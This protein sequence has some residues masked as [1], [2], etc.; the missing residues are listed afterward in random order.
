VKT[1]ASAVVYFPPHPITTMSEEMATLVGNSLQE[2]TPM[3]MMSHSHHHP[4]LKLPQNYRSN[5]GAAGGGAIATSSRPP[6]YSRHPASPTKAS[7]TALTKSTTSTAT[8]TIIPTALEKKCDEYSDDDDDDDVDDLASPQSS[9]SSSLCWRMDPVESLSDWT[10]S[11]VHSPTGITRDYHV[12]RVVL[13]VGQRTCGYFQNLFFRTPTHNMHHHQPNNNNNNNVVQDDDDNLNDQEKHAVND[14][15]SD[16]VEPGAITSKAKVSS[17][18]SPSPAANQSSSWTGSSVRIEFAR[19]EVCDLFPLFLDFLYGKDIMNNNNNMN[20]NDNHHNNLDKND[21]DSVERSSQ[22]STTSNASVL[23]THTAVGLYYLA[24]FFRQPQLQI[25]VRMF[26]RQDLRFETLA[27]YYCDVNY[28]SD[29]YSEGSSIEPSITTGGGDDGNDVEEEE[30]EFLEQLLTLVAQTCAQEIRNVEPT[31][32]LLLEMSPD[33]LETVLLL[34]TTTMTNE[35]P[36]RLVPLPMS[37]QFYHHLSILVAEYCILHPLQVTPDDFQQLTMPERL[38]VLHVSAALKLLRLEQDIVQWRTGFLDDEGGSGG[39]SDVVTPVKAAASPTSVMT[40]N[41]RSPEGGR[42]NNNS[43][44]NDEGGLTNLQ[45]RCIVSLAKG[46][47]ELN[48]FHRESTAETLQKLPT[49]VVVELMHAIVIR[50]DQQMIHLNEKV[51]ATMHR[52]LQLKAN[53][54]HVGQERNQAHDQVHSLEDRL[55]IV[56]TEFK[57]Q[58]HGLIKRDEL[59]EKEKLAFHKKQLQWEEERQ[60]FQDAK[61]EWKEAKLEL[62]DD[63]REAKKEIQYWK[64]RYQKQK[65]YNSHRPRRVGSYDSAY[66]DSPAEQ[67]FR[68]VDSALA[69]FDSVTSTTY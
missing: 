1:T 57:E 41:H 22:N 8:T 12:H 56:K 26:I 18:P 61:E 30:E 60:A 46:W 36:F 10:I 20:T 5:T 65:K 50:A 6:L 58:V 47:V 7:G 23:S 25:E 39:G 38:P 32:T 52:E 24:R 33:F 14:D 69:S 67:A 3:T 28:Y 42:S 44:Q 40:T 54:D 49:A 59:Y 45:Q 53:Y 48:R 31:S 68:F 15:D 29:F 34:A 16:D 62:K 21:Q 4:N 43:T 55:V 64:G 27:Q 19:K 63:L 51:N 35:R 9:S 11:I 13:A 2:T 66:D 17:L 37:T